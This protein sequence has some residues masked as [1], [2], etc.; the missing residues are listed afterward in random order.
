[1]KTSKISS[2]VCLKRIA[3]KSQ[4]AKDNS[5]VNP[6]VSVV[7]PS[8]NSARWIRQCLR[9]TR[10][11]STELPFEVIVVD[12]S[13]DGTEQI[14]VNEFPEVRLFHFQERRSVGTARNIGVEKARGEVVLFLDTDCVAKETWIGQMY[15]AIKS[16]GAD[17]V[18]GSVEN[19]TSWS[20]TGSV[21][22][23]LEFFRFLAYNG[24]PYTTIFFIGGN[25]GFRREVF[26]SAQYDNMNVGDDFTF[27]WQLAK[28][29]KKLLFLPSVSIRHMNKTGLLKVLRYQYELGMGAYAYRHN[30]SPSIIRPLESL[31]ILTFLMPVGIMAWIGC[32]VLRRR[33]VL[34]F[35]KFLLLLP[36]LYVANNVWAIGFYR[37]L[38]NRKSK[39]R[40]AVSA[41]D[42]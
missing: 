37:A 34:E 10:A 19:G 36:L 42:N 16:L 25:S 11:Q 8:Y 24:R 12:S 27:A 2:E 41:I 39:R 28:Q 35:F 7:I 29:K 9:A 30:V 17:G 26:R 15:T 20:I 1:M 18:G 21:G 3:T 32:I 33:G 23:Y 31:A 38:R 6:V 5:H 13:D 4:Q 40:H 22:F 14:V